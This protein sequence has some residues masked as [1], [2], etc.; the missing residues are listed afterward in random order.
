MN[1]FE[2]GSDNEGDAGSIM[3][4]AMS[5]DKTT[6][7][8][9]VTIN[10]DLLN[11]YYTYSVTRGKTT[12]ETADVY[13]KACGVNGQRS[14][15]VDLSTTN[16]DGWENDK[17]VLVQNQTDASVWEISVADFSSSESSGVS[18]ANR[19]KYLA[20]TE[21]GT[22]VNGVQGASSTCVDYLKSS[23]LSMFRLCR[24]MISVL[25]TRART[26]WT[27]TTGATIPSTTTA[28]RVLIQQ[29]L[30]G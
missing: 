4:R 17:H 20:F 22:T 25:L 10:G 5:L 1:I 18:E 28:P 15:V 12:K 14:M 3:S 24:S 2:H 27:S 13:A 21:E 26:L 8:W 7:V 11:K 19:G 30:K 29:I 9:S 6:G 23:A 16:P